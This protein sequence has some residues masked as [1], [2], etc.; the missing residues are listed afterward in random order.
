MIY[1]QDNFLPKQ[2]HK[3]LVEYCD[4]FDEVETPGKSFWVKELPSELIHYIERSLEKIEGKDI[5]SILTR[6]LKWVILKT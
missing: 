4:K 3:E 5:K 1:I 6:C 2:L